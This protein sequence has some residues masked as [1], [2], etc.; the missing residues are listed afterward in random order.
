M[1]KFKSMKKNND[2]KEI[3]YNENTIGTFQKVKGEVVETKRTIACIELLNIVYDRFLSTAKKELI[4]DKITE[5]PKNIFDRIVLLN[6][7]YIKTNSNERDV[8]SLG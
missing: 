4:E 6:Q 3:R 2:H 1:D 8:R 5:T 7:E